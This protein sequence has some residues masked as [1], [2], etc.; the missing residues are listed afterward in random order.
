M[1][2]ALRLISIALA[3]LWLAAAALADEAI[4]QFSSVI[5]LSKDGSMLV[6][7]TIRVRGEGIKIRRGIYR[8][9]PMVFEGASGREHQ[10]GFEVVSVRR[11]GRPEDYRTEAAG[12]ATRV[13]MGNADR[14]LG[15]GTFTYELTYRTD[16]Q[17]R[18]F[19][20]HDEMFWN[21]TGNFWDFPIIN[22]SAEFR[23]PDG[24]RAED[25][26]VFTG[27]LGSRERNASASIRGGGSRV[28]A[29]TSAPLR[30]RE[31]WSVAIRMP[32]GS[33]IPPTSQQELAWFWRDNRPALISFAS[34]LFLAIYYFWAWNRVGRDPQAGVIVPRWDAPDGIS[35]ALVHYIDNK[36]LSGND[37]FS[38][39]LLSLAVKGYVTLE[40][41]SGKDMKIQ[42]TG[43]RP[44]SGSL[45]VGEQLIYD[46]VSN[47]SGGFRIDK[48][49]GAS[50]VSLASR[51]RQKLA[52]EHRNKY[53]IRNLP[54]IAAGVA[55]SLGAIV[56]SISTSPTDAMLAGPFLAI[57]VFAVAVTTILFSIGAK[58]FQNRGSG[59]F[60][61]A[62]IVRWFVFGIVGFNFLPGL[63]ALIASGGASPLLI[64]AV[65][66][67]VL[68]N[69]LFW[70]LMGAPTPLGR[71]LMDGIEGLR[72]YVTLAEKDRLNLQGAPAMSPQHFETVLPYAVAL[73]LEKPW[74]KAFE[75]WLA[76][77]AGAAAAATY[78]PGWYHGSN[79]SGRSIGTELGGVADSISSSMT[80]AAPAPKSS[81][82]GF[83][84]GGGGGSGGGG[85]GGG[86]GGW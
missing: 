62:N 74:T 83:G 60:N 84:G 3:S 59:G 13:Y 9:F 70:Y 38:A 7:E 40:E 48:A 30:Q 21:V 22:S 56:L 2:T 69:A 85:G 51:F 19:N 45:P 15:P 78:N 42:S 4:E 6:T 37:A 75:A 68:L 54:W 23:L 77:A 47:R 72:T 39:S 63:G 5:E 43:A 1:K 36:G 57:A 10:V 71:R 33:I 66:S 29:A 44:P 58:M 8:D 25:V 79:F 17:I 20:T 35:P 12:R 52:A 31:G 53:F 61:F 49:N 11:D 65:G 16:R 41:L 80:N 46:A 82:S 32:K 28:V 14:F 55:M 26:A 86:G 81:S 67:I 76:T 18:F 34:F 24:A 27:P 73:G 64:T 50:V